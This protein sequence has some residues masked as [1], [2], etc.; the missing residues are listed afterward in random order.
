MDVF[1]LANHNMLAKSLSSITT[2]A[3]VSVPTKD[4]KSLGADENWYKNQ[5]LDI[6]HIPITRR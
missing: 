4:N 6:V 2:L 3:M 1:I 5:S